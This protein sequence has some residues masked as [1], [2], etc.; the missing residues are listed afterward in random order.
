MLCSMNATGLLLEILAAPKLKGFVEFITRET[1]TCKSKLATVLCG[2]SVGDG[3]TQERERF[4]DSK[5]GMTV[6]VST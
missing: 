5:E 4:F 3:D 2:V 1:R 6:P